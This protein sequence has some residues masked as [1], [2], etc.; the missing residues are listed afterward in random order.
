MLKSILGLTG[1]RMSPWKWLRAP[2]A[3]IAAITILQ[4][5]PSP[6]LSQGR[7]LKATLMQNLD[8]GII[9][10][11]TG[12]GTVTIQPGGAKILSAGIM[13]LGGVSAPAI[14]LVQGEKYQAFTISLPGSATITLPGGI[15]AVLTNFESTPSLIGTLDNRGQA[16]V[17]VGATL[18][19]TPQL[20]EGVYTDPF[21]IIVSYQ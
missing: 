8:F 7:P 4:L 14:F 19:V 1:T 2:A 16:I 3:V 18:N 10:A 20:W 11:T 17:T 13:D 15:S 6:V 21:D 9:G 5:T 12:S